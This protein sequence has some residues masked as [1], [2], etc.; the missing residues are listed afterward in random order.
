[1]LK[2]GK[3]GDVGMHLLFSSDA[4]SCVDVARGLAASKSVG[5]DQERGG[6]L[7]LAMPATPALAE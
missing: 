3:T 7:I 6:R 4:P 1:M 2:G 5:G